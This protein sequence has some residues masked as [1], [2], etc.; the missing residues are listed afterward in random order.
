ME[1]VV[2]LNV[3]AG[4]VADCCVCVFSCVLCCEIVSE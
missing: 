3:T 1:G 2:L 4:N